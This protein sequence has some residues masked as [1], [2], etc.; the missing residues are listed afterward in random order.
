MRFGTEVIVTRGSGPRVGTGMLREVRGTLIGARGQEC[1][2]R[3]TED[4][5]LSSLPEWSKTGDVGN[6]GRSVVRKA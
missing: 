6:W 2:V 1:W 3:L 4:D 5:A